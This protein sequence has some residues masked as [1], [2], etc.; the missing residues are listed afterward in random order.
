MN[1]LTYQGK[2]HVELISGHYTY[3]HRCAGHPSFIC[4][5]CCMTWGRSMKSVSRIKLNLADAS[6]AYVIVDK[7]EDGTSKSY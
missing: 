3:P 6:K 5:H 1:A 2:E 4:C 7:K